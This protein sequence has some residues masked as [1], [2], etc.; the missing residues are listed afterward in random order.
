MVDDGVEADSLDRHAVGARRGDLVADVAEP[1]RPA[2]AFRTGF[3][4]DDRTPVAVIHIGEP[5]FRPLHDLLADVYHRYRRPIVVAETGS[6]GAGRAPWRPR[7]RRS[8]TT[9]RANGVAV[10]GV[11]LYPVVDHPG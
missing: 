11:C 3:G 10:E 6:E 4:H 1:R 5:G 9:A 7:R 2:R 8:G